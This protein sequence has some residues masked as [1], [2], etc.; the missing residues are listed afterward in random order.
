L[1]PRQPFFLQWVFERLSPTTLVKTATMVILLVPQT[2]PSQEKGPAPPV[3][4]HTVTIETVPM[5]TITIET[6]T[7]PGVDLKAYLTGLS[8]IL[9]RY[10]TTSARDNLVLND[11]GIVFIKATVQRNGTLAPGSPM[12][13]I[14]SGNPKLDDASLATVNAAAPFDTLPENFK[15]EKLEL[16]IIFRYAY[17]PDAPYKDIYESAQRAGANQE[18]DT[19]AQLLE[20]LVAKDP[21][22][23]NGWN[24]L[25]WI[26]TKLGK[27]DKAVIALKKA[28]EVNPRDPN[29][30]NNLGQALASQKKY[31]EAV[32]QYQKQIEINKNDR[33]A[34]ANLGRVYLELQENEKALQELET[35]EGITP[36]DPGVYYTLGR[37]Y[38]KSNQTQKAKEAFKKSLEIEPVP[39]RLNNV[40][41]QMAMSQLDLPTAQRYA[42]SGI[43][44]LVLKMRETSLDAPGN[45]DLRMTAWMGILWDTLGWILFQEGKVPE[46]EKYVMGA[47][48]LHSVGEVGYHLGRVYEAGG[49]KAE[50]IRAYELAL[51]ATRPNNEAREHL[52][53]LL[54][55]ASD[56][57]KRVEQAR[58]QLTAMRTIKVPN[59]H[60]VEGVADFWILLAPG[61][62]VVGVK[63]LTGDEALRPFAEDLEKVSYPEVFP[64]ATEL[65]LL[66]KGRLSCMR[67]GGMSCRLLLTSAETVTTAE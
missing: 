42:E 21:D 61:P 50:A 11:K 28:I 18:Y 16:R 44:A 57:D 32:P 56:I 27:H 34:H 65:R 2:T 39:M 22:Y 47:W 4:L 63:F 31:E 13:E 40:A 19:A 59:E 8:A 54:G 9:K 5:H 62:R 15:G 49:R 10:W 6:V 29:A 46:A 14:A 26:Y 51:G 37:A 66:R 43:A 53:L 38:L 52:T 12:V 35:A 3:P 23:T 20:G 48:Q 17:L 7:L 25:G 60:D 36:K 64:E 1:L 58:A 67:E 41:Y 24:Y 30:H 33:Y 45:E 55:S